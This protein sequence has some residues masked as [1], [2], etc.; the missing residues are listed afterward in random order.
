MNLFLDTLQ[1]VPFETLRE[2]FLLLLTCWGTAKSLILWY[3]SRY[4]RV[5][6]GKTQCE[7]ALIRVWR[8]FCVKEVIFIFFNV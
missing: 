3:R 5:T 4:Y 7:P 6:D 2:I 1:S 8:G